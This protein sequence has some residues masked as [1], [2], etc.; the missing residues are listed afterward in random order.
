MRF[1]FVDRKDKYDAKIKV[2][3]I[4]DSGDDYYGESPSFDIIGK[5]TMSQPD[6]ADIKINQSGVDAFGIVWNAAGVANVS[7]YYSTQDGGAGTYNFIGTAAGSA[8]GLDWDTPDA[9]GN[10]VR[11]KLIDA[12]EA[13]DTAEVNAISLI[14]SLVEDFT[15][16]NPQNGVNLT[17]GAAVS[18]TWAKLGDSLGTVDLYLSKDGGLNYSFIKQASNTGTSAWDVPTNVR[19]IQCKVR[20]VS[21]ELSSN[22]SASS[23]VFVIKNGITVTDP[24]ASTP[25]WSVGSP[26]DITWDFVGPELKEDL[27]PVKVKIEYSPTGQAV[28]YATIPGAAS[29]DIGTGG[30]GTWEWTIDLATTLCTQG[31]IR[32]T[33]AEIATA[34]D[35]SEGNLEIRGDI[36][37]DEITTNPPSF[38]V[39]KVADNYD[40]TWTKYGDVQNLNFY[41]KAGAGSW[42]LINTSSSWNAGTQPYVWVVSDAI[43]NSVLLKIEDADNPSVFNETAN[44]FRI[45]GKIVLDKPGVAEPDWVVAQTRNIQWTPTGTYS[46]VKIEGSNDDFSST[47]PIATRPAG[48][49]TQLQTYEF[50]VTDHIGDNVKVRIF[51]SDAT[52]WDLVIATSPAFTIKGALSVTTPI[53]DWFVGETNRTIN[54]NATGTVGNVHLEYDDGTVWH[55]ITD[56]SVGVPTGGS[57]SGPGSYDWPAVGDAKTSVARLRVTDLDD[58]TGSVKD[59]SNTFAIWPLITVDEPLQDV[60]VEVQSSNPD[61]IKWSIDGTLVSQIDIYY[62]TDGGSN[63]YPN[64]INAAAVTA[65]LGQYDWNSVPVT[66]TDNARI[67]IIDVDDGGDDE[68][69]EECLI[70]PA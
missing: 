56:P 65:S 10:S 2:I 42:T 27:S 15:G 63:G 38:T 30:S 6:G 26:Y 9:V 34:T 12:T 8:G 49:S 20:V 64:K 32:V 51:D 16:I 62:D 44:T 7:A 45:I 53:V 55:D 25:P 67:K 22:S 68:Y 50:T 52:R 66:P 46:S 11:V 1:E 36:I 37:P 4:D 58:V 35:E 69:I 13:V 21:T 33:D 39:L 14:F 3:D 57:G 24:N 19:S 60:D 31:K 61:L 23:G 5:I 43:D 40:V 54:W 70:Q 41:Y 28:D 47:W 17:C 29:I 18:I 48:T 59:T